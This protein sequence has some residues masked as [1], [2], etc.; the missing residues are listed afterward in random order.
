MNIP[1]PQQLLADG[2]HRRAARRDR[3]VDVSAMRNQ[4]RAADPGNGGDPDSRHP[5]F[6]PSGPLG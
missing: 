6:V 1:A 2:V 4:A 5:L 3:R